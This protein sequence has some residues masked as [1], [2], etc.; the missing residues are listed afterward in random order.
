MICVLS[1]ALAAASVQPRAPNF[2]YFER[3]VKCEIFER[4]FVKLIF[5][6]F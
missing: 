6:L 4:F 2:Q 1:I 5:E 3:Y